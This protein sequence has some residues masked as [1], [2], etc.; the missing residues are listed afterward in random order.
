[1]RA[2]PRIRG[3][4]HLLRHLSP[5]ITCEWCH[6]LYKCQ[7]KRL[8]HLLN[9]QAW[10][11]ATSILYKVR[12][13]TKIILRLALMYQK[14]HS[15]IKNHLHFQNFHF[16]SPPS[17][18]GTFAMKPYTYLFTLRLHHNGVSPSNLPPDAASDAFCHRTPRPDDLP[19]A[20]S[21]MQLAASGARASHDITR[22][23][24]DWGLPGSPMNPVT[25]SMWAL[26][27]GS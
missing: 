26:E 4:K 5:K 21:L 22:D 27:H 14:S 10:G 6:V 7:I 13:I 23:G 25:M 16:V 12:K 3:G 9:W 15:W 20:V 1:M 18:K 8:P 2:F 24:L 19:S 11:I 17:S